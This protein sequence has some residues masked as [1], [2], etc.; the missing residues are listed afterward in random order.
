VNETGSAGTAN[1]HSNYK[2]LGKSIF[3]MK[4]MPYINFFP[5]SAL[6]CK[7]LM[8]GMELSNSTFKHT[9]THKNS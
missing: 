7:P 3:H 9:H 4:K 5:V 8:H 6:Q 2:N 1:K